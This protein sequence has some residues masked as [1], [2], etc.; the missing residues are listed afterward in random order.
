MSVGGASAPRLT[1][2]GAATRRRIVEGAAEEIRERGVTGT[3]L[4]DIRARTAT[5]K[6]QIFHYFPGGKEELLLAVAA[7]EAERVLEDQEP[8]LSDLGTW[9]AWQGWRDAVVQRYERQGVNC[10][11]GMLITE[12]GRATPAAKA[13]TSQLIGQWQAA[14][15]SGIRRLQDSG[16]IGGDL[17]ADRTAAALVAAVQGGVT[18]LMSTGAISHLEAALDTT[19]ALLRTTAATM[20]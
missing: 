4:D 13:L 20:R 18:I 19:L 3:T 16:E 12:L 7:R 10:P 8:H 9:S 1:S 17:D 2:K 6:S 14:L 15:S 5:S 11:L